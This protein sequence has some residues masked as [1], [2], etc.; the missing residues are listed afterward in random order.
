MALDRFA[1]DAGFRVLNLGTGRGTSVLELVDAFGAA[2]GQPIAYEIV[3]R[4]P[5]DVDALVA[6]PSRAAE[7]L[8]WRTRRTLEDMC[9]DAWRFQTQHPNGY[10]GVGDQR[11]V[12]PV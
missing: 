9:R 11:T 3:G 12:R 1:G 5:G 10:D 2:C 6:D 8:G 4:R 7:V